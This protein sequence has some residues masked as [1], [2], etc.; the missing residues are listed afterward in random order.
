MA[1]T[2]KFAIGNTIKVDGNVVT[3]ESIHAGYIVAKDKKC[4]SKV[5]TF[6]KLES[7]KA[8]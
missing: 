5:F 8:E 1:Q 4:V 7:L 3:I 6:D 2:P